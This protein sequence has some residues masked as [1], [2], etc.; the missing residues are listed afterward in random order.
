MKNTYL[1]EFEV[2][3]T[4]YVMVEAESED[5]AINLAHE[6]ENIV[7]VCECDNSSETVLDVYQGEDAERE[8]KCLTEDLGV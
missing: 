3:K 5:Q 4:V 6:R 7:D 2:A 8:W 1:I